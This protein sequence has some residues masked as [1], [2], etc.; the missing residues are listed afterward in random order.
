MDEPAEI[1]GRQGL[2]PAESL[3]WHPQG[4]APAEIEGLRGLHLAELSGSGVRDLPPGRG[5]GALFSGRGLPLEA[6]HPVPQA[7]LLLPA[8]GRLVPKDTEVKSPANWPGPQERWE[9]E[10][11]W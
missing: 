4:L 6:L 1:S 11:R 7:L 2:H 5:V 3:G 8:A 10:A 9:G